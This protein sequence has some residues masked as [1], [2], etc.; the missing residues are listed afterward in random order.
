MPPI[1]IENRAA[2]P[3]I[4]AISS[5]ADGVNYQIKVPYAKS[6]RGY[7][8]VNV[9]V[10]PSGMTHTTS[11]NRSRITPHTAA[12]IVEKYRKAQGGL[13]PKRNLSGSCG[14][15]VQ[16]PFCQPSSMPMGRA[17]GKIKG[18]FC[19]EKKSPTKA[20]DPRSFRWKSSGKGKAWL[21]VGCPKGAWQPRK[22]SCAVGL[23]LHAI[24]RRTQGACPIGT[25]RLAK[26]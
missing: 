23:K 8:L 26:G 1:R 14:G 7:D 4:L 25:K 17:A 24:L 6:P 11:A 13:Q 22:K 19:E 12:K 18:T 16:G 3:E 15:S 9:L 20:F 5:R 2:Y 10:G 21:L